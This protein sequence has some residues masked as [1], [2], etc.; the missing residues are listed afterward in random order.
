MKNLTYIFSLLSFFLF[1]ACIGDDFI[2]DQ[3]EAEIRIDA[4]VESIEVNTDYQFEYTYLNEVGQS[5][6]VEVVWSSSN[7]EV[8]TIDEN[9]LAQA[10]TIGEVRIMVSYDNGT[11]VLSDQIDLMIGSTTI[12]VEKQTFKGNIQTTSSYVLEGS[13]ELKEEDQGLSLSFEED[14]KASTA[15]PGLFIYLSNNRNSIAN[16]FEIGAVEVFNGQHNYTIENVEF[17]DY[18]FIVYF[19]KPFNVKVG[20]GSLEE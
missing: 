1:F 14:Y 20:D 6:Q 13:F 5:Q 19:C 17:N 18:K 7:E 3:V 12:I 15:L 2:E 11:I 16:A 10:I 4:N 8:M 9:G